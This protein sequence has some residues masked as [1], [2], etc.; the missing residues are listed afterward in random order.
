[1]KYETII[2]WN[3]NNNTLCLERWSELVPPC[4]DL[5]TDVQN[6]FNWWLGCQLDHLIYTEFANWK[7]LFLSAM[8]FLPNFTCCPYWQSHYITPSCRH[9]IAMWQVNLIKKEERVQPW[10][11]WE[12]PT[13]QQSCNQYLNLKN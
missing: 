6:Y 8:F 2:L 4:Q 12:H 10:M 13:G 1:M 11:I 9:C 5:M 3:T 7:Q